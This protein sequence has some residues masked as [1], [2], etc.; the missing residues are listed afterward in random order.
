MPAGKQS[1]TGRDSRLFHILPA[2]RPD[3]P[4]RRPPPS[5]SA[6][7]LSRRLA[8]LLILLVGAVAPHGLP[9]FLLL[10]HGHARSTS[11][12]TAMVSAR[13]GFRSIAGIVSSS[14]SRRAIPARA[15]SSRTTAST[16]RSLRARDKSFCSA[17]PAPPIP[18]SS[19][20]WSK[21]TPD[22]PAGA[23]AR[24]EIDLPEPYL[25]RPIARNRARRPDRRPQP[26]SPCR[27]RTPGRHPPC[28]PAPGT[29]PQPVCDLPLA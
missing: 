7:R 12:H 22:C 4:G 17:S 5:D 29:P 20:M 19:T 9:A 21:S 15:S 16:S 25:Q 6:N 3:S 8:S 1:P 10:L 27:P 2:S 24:L 18:L 13:P 28:R 11:R 26:P 14:P 23:V